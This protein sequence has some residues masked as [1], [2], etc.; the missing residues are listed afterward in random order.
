[1]NI[2]FHIPILTCLCS[3]KKDYVNKLQYS[4]PKWHY[5]VTDFMPASIQAFIIYSICCFGIHYFTVTTAFLTSMAVDVTCC[6]LI[7]FLFNREALCLCN[8]STMLWCA[9]MF[10]V[11]TECEGRLEEKGDSWLLLPVLP[12]LTIYSRGQKFWDLHK[13]WFSPS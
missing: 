1:M 3:V 5:W 4:N 8:S 13:Y 11:L 12:L 6:W 7:G 2:L 9:A 10:C